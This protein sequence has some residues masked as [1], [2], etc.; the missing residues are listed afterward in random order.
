[1]KVSGALFA[2]GHDAPAAAGNSTSAHWKGSSKE[3]DL[4]GTVSR[5][6]VAEY[7]GREE[8]PL[9]FMALLSLKAVKYMY[10]CPTGHIMHLRLGCEVAEPVRSRKQETRVSLQ[11]SFTGFC[12]PDDPELW[13]FTLHG[14]EVLGVAGTSSPP[15]RGPQPSSPNSHQM[16]TRSKTPQRGPARPPDNHWPSASRGQEHAHF[17]PQHQNQHYTGPGEFSWRCVSDV[18]CGSTL[19]CSGSALQVKPSAPTDKD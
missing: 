18:P 12:F 6:Q 15:S 4:A 1:M 16:Q 19:T 17:R 5:H 14:P 8:I 10:I 7:A 13:D 9:R 3:D 2:A 11:F